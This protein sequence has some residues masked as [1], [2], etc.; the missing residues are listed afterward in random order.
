MAQLEFIQ[1]S[2]PDLFRTCMRTAW[3]AAERTSDHISRTEGATLR[4]LA[5]EAHVGAAERH[6]R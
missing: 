2:V 1:R 4:R 6:T 3:L 5:N